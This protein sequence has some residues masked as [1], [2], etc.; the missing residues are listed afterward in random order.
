MLGDAEA[1]SGG[2]VYV[3][4]G[5]GK[6]QFALGAL[7]TFE[8]T[9]WD[10]FTFTGVVDLNGDGLDDLVW[11]KQC[12]DRS[13]SCEGSATLVVRVGLADQRDRRRRPERGR[14][15]RLGRRVD[16]TQRHGR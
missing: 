14:P 13:S 10:N 6:G 1:A 9:G 3:A 4:L 15:L 16:R 2:E 7:Q 8:S 11:V 5:D 12:D